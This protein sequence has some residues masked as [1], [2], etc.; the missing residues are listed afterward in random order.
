MKTPVPLQPLCIALDVPDRDELVR[1]AGLVAPHAGAL[2]IGLTA[3]TS[4]GPSIVA[5]LARSRPM[6]LDLKLHD[7]PAQVRGAVAAGAATGASWI[8]VHAAGGAAMVEAA[9]EAAPAGCGVLAVTILTSLGERDLEEIGLAGPAEEAVTRLA[10]LALEA[11]ATGLVCSPLEV[12]SLRRRFGSVEDGGPLLVVPGIR[13]VGAATDD[14]RRTLSA[15][16]AIAAGANMLVVGRPIT[17]S[18]D[19]ARAAE[20]MAGLCV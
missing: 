19:P 15:A 17:S 3:F 16:E 8:T 5:E 6:F 9:A 13:A 4:C 11:G 12:A 20:E 2:K 7:I 18:P 10:E 14:Q 1:L